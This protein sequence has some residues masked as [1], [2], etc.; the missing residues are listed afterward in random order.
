[1]LPPQSRCRSGTNQGRGYGTRPL[2][3]RCDAPSAPTDCVPELGV[4]YDLTSSHRTNA[5]LIRRHV[6]VAERRRGHDAGHRSEQPRSRPVIEPASGPLSCP[7]IAGRRR[8]CGVRLRRVREPKAAKK[9]QIR[10]WWLPAATFYLIV[11]GARFGPLIAAATV[12]LAAIL[13]ALAEFRARRRRERER[14]YSPSHS[15]RP[16]G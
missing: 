16:P 6:S 8:D 2:S 11:V 5:A 12:A 3:R 9:R 15:T 7:P 13:V 10:W 1:M 14:P 4:I